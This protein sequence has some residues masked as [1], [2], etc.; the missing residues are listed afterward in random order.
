V[1]DDRKQAQ[2]LLE[3][4]LEQQHL[5]M[6]INQRIRTSLNLPETL[7]ITV[8]EIR[9]ILKTDRVII[10]QFSPQWRGKVLTESVGAEWTAILSTQIYDPCFGENYVELYKQGLVTAKSDI[11]QAGIDPCHLELLANFQVRANLVVPIVKKDELWGLLI[12]HHCQEPRQWQDSEIDLMRQLAAQV[13]IAIQ[14]SELFLQLETELAERKQIEASLRQSE[15]RY[16]S[17]IYASAQIVWHTDAEGKAIIVPEGW[18]E[19]IG[20]P[21]TECL[22]YGWLRVVH[23][24]DRDRTLQIWLE[25]CINQTIYETEYRLRIKD[26]TYHLFAVRGVPILDADGQISEWIGSCK[27]ITESKQAEIVLQQINAKLE[28]RVAERTAE[29]REVNDRLEE[30]LL[31]RSRLQRQLLERT[32]LLDSFF[33]AASAANI[34]LAIHDRQLNYLKLNQALADINGFPIEA[35]IGRNLAETLPDIAT[36]IKPILQKVIETGQAIRRLEITETT[37]EQPGSLHYWLVSYFPIFGEAEQVVAVGAIVLDITERKR[38]EETLKHTHDQLNFHIENTPLATIIWDSQFRVQH[39][40]KQAERIFGWSAPEVLGKKMS[41]W[42]FIFEADLEVVNARAKN[43][44]KG[45]RTLCNNR[46]YRKDGAVIDCEWY[47]SALLDESGNLV[48][49]LSLAQDVSERKRAEVALQQ[50]HTE[51]LQR[52]TQ[53]EVVNRELEDTLQELQTTEEEV[54][55]SNNQLEIVLLAAQLERQRYQDLFNFAPDGYLV[56]DTN[57]V[58]QEANQAAGKLFMVDPS[59]LVGKPLSVYISEQDTP[60][61]RTNLNQ[62][63]RL[64]SGQSYEL[65][66]EP[67]QGK[68]FPASI[69]VSPI[70]EPRRQVTGIRWLIRDIRERKQ[71][72]AALRESEEKFRQLAEN[73]QAVFWISDYQKQQVIYVSHAYEKIWQRPREDVYHNCGN[74]FNAVHPSDRPL[75]AAAMNQQRE[76][77]QSDTIYR[78]IRPDGSIRWIRDRAFPI[79]TERGEI[80]RIAGIA[81]DITEQQQIEEMKNEFIGIVSHELRTPLT[82]IQMSL[83]LLQTGVYNKNPEKFQRMLNIALTDTKR[84]VNLVNDILDLERLQSG[85]IV[86]EKTIFPAAD[87]IQQVVNGMEALATAQKVKLKINPTNVQVTAARDAIGQT[88]TNLLSNALKFSPA[89]STITLSAES[90]SNMVLFQV[91]DQGRGIPPDK[92]EAIFGRFQQVDASDSREKGGTGLGLAICQSIVEQHGGK[93][94]VE[95]VLGKG[96]TFFF[97]LPILI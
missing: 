18:E 42:R 64:F 62:L 19:L 1:I 59:I 14:Q 2:S 57:G 95:S 61:F 15:L 46:N 89:N 50:A 51:L 30:E 73:I 33:N 92:L 79:K 47:N 36:Q 38:I 43:L 96:S 77:G 39:W 67:R 35:L 60:V 86:L 7:Q 28:T 55:E 23:P 82:A 71:A 52:S 10:L 21:A 37:S 41:D 49:I 87:L 56:T 40:S 26:G 16:R 11:Y 54:R 48:S 65:T 12:A 78:I 93:I 4:Q 44:L 81:E 25:C 20:S 75:V 34:G 13:S 91:S 24:D 32:R 97:T 5:V 58:I 22:D 31:L 90:Q 80:F 29:L 9:R 66:I 6:E 76:T 45:D 69:T 74:S 94:W 27:D 8:D 53:L 63:K 85:R 68:S 88:L 72:E 84:L 3:Q 83:G 17:L 70:C